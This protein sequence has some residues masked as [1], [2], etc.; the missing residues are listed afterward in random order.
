[1][2]TLRKVYPKAI[3]A[4]AIWSRSNAKYF[5]TITADFIKMKLAFI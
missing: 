3:E 4:K 2:D 1:M 5:K